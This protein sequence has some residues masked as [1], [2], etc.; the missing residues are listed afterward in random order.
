MAENGRDTGAGAERWKLALEIVGAAAAIGAWVAVV[1]GAVLY[2]RLENA[3]IPPLPTVSDLPRGLLIAEG[4]HALL[5]PLL[6]GGALAVLTYLSRAK[7]IPSSSSGPI[8]AGLEEPADE[9]RAAAKRA[10][11]AAM[12]AS[13]KRQ[14]AQ[15][16]LD[17]L[18]DAVEDA[19]R[20]VKDRKRPHGSLLRP[21]EG[22]GA[23]SVRRSSP[24]SERQR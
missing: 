8:E 23:R 21:L 15:N 1:G 17:D 24:T 3:H 6:I 7:V 9:R 12:F 5:I 2:A 22:P 10:N 20:R 13:N 14:A 19:A 18:Y 4:A 11:D 16:A